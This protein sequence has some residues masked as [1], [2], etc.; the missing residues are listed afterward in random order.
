M[1]PVKQKGWGLAAE[2][3]RAMTN[4]IAGALAVIVSVGIGRATA[5]LR[6]ELDLAPGRTGLAS[7]VI[8][9]P[10]TGLWLLAGPGAGQAGDPGV[11]VLF[12]G[13]APLVWID[14]RRGILPDQITLPLIALGALLG[15]AAGEG[16]S[17]V[18]G[19]AAGWLSL[20]ALGAAWRRL[21][22]I[23]ALG[24]GDA[25][26]FAAIG[27]FLGI[28]ALP[29]AALLGAVIGIVWAGVR[30]LTAGRARL[31]EEIPFGPALAAGAAIRWAS[32][33]LF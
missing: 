3:G 6:P 21:R 17:R 2:K 16:A 11:L 27:A 8:A 19:A 10:L 15:I 20:W 14:A 4:L 32:G 22:G 33:P 25:K 7:G 1:A 23:D 13:L 30:G 5:W 18:A 26:L 29:D 12:A 31:G 9:L 24:L 28:A